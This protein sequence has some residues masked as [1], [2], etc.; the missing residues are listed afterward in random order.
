M[1]PDRAGK[2]FE[3]EAGDLRQDDA[4]AR[5]PVGHDHVERADAI[6]GDDQQARCAVWQQSVVDIPHFAAASARQ[7]QVGRQ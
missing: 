2:V 4:L 1:V 3:P 7:W 5:Q 6:S